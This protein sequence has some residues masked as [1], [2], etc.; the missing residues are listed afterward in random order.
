[1]VQLLSLLTTVLHPDFLQRVGRNCNKAFLVV[2][3]T[4]GGWRGEISFPSP[5][6]LCFKQLCLP[7][8]QLLPLCLKRYC[9][10]WEWFSLTPPFWTFLKALIMVCLNSKMLFTHFIITVDRS[11]WKINAL[12]LDQ[13]CKVETLVKFLSGI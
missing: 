12:G 6:K 9:L 2:L 8:C 5:L 11:Q 1:M 4:L 13:A 10:F 7:D 3:P